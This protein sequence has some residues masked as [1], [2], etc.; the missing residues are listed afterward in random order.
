MMPVKG[1][2]KIS[3]QTNKLEAID[4]IATAFNIS[5]PTAQPFLPCRVLMSSNQRKCKQIKNQGVYLIHLIY[6]FY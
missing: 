6:C 4:S 3:K 1:K 2:G 5:L